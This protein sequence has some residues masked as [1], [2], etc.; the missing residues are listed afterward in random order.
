MQEFAARRFHPM[1][2][3]QKLG[4][5]GHRGGG[6]VASGDQ[7]SLAVNIGQNQFHE[8]RALLDA[9]RDLAPF[10][11]LDEKRH[12]R[13][14]PGALARIPVGAIGDARI[15][16][17]PVGGG[18][19]LADVVGAEFHQRGEKPQPMRARAPVRADEFVRDARQRPVAGRECGHPRGCVEIC[20]WK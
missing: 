11:G 4:A 1:Q 2:G 7:P 18:E 10:A 3:V 16:N 8:P 15:A 12:M 14:R 5:A 13:E 6:Q 17:M 9:S 20:Y 19:A